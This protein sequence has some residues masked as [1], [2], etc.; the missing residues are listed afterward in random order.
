MADPM[1][2]HDKWGVEAIQ[3]KRPVAINNF[4]QSTKHESGR[5]LQNQVAVKSSSWAGLVKW[6]RQLS[7]NV[8]A[9]QQRSSRTNQL[10]AAGQ[11][12][13]SQTSQDVAG[14]AAAG[15]TM[16]S[17]ICQGNAQTAAAGQ[18]RS[19]KTKHGD[20]KNT[21][22][23][24]TTLTNYMKPGI[25]PELVPQ[26]GP[27]VQAR[28]R[29]RL[30]LS[31][32]D[33]KDSAEVAAVGQ[34]TASPA[35]QSQAH[36]G[37]LDTLMYDEDSAELTAVGQATA[38]S[39]RQSEARTGLLETRMY[40]E[41]NMAAWEP[42]E[43]TESLSTDGPEVPWP[44]QLFAEACSLQSVAAFRTSAIY[45]QCK[46]VGE[47]G[48]GSSGVVY[49]GTRAPGTQPVAIKICTRVP[50]SES[51]ELSHMIKAQGAHILVLLDAFVSP[52]SSVQV[53]ELMDATLHAHVQ[54]SPLHNALY[55]SH[56]K[57]LSADDSRIIAQHILKGLGHLH[58]KG[59]AHRDLHASNM[60]VK[61]Q[62]CLT[63]KLANLG[64]A[65][66]VSGRGPEIVTDAGWYTW[67]HRPPEMLLAKGTRWSGPASPPS[68]SRNVKVDIFKCDLW[69][70]GMCILTVQVGNPISAE[71]VWIQAGRLAALC[72]FSKKFVKEMDWSL[73]DA[74]LPGPRKFVLDPSLSGW[75]ESSL[76]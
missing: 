12:R 53:F 24:Q 9:G 31:S 56:W 8:A 47:L 26:G 34:A 63:V 51:A 74:L 28:R 37:L 76:A 66:E 15:Q 27:A 69:A 4:G 62:P 59:L 70:A 72:G 61:T 46:L 13:S 52:R 21:D 55:G 3:R 54:A 36:T 33:H 60:L 25:H 6:A 29:L 50:Q 39:A 43:V 14:A 19:S 75:R 7:I 1:A 17:Q 44:K 65:I 71:K 18:A 30:R 41:H 58:E 11:A 35:C 22:E 16:P 68:P 10:S 49:K 20:D 57:V 64:R 40:D 48:Q 23:G 2:D 32:Q 73:P 67:A 38:A 42:V 5:A 45:E